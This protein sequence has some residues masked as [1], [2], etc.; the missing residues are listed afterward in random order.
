MM[1]IRLLLTVGCLDGA[2][3]DLAWKPH[4]HSWWH[5]LFS[6]VVFRCNKSCF[7]PCVCVCVDD[8][9]EEEEA[10]DGIR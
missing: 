3:V 7:S 1:K 5:T 8:G 9:A 4:L 10:E 6:F 2:P